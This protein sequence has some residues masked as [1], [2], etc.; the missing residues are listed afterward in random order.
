[1]DRELEII[2]EMP[3]LES[4]PEERVKYIMALSTDDEKI[5]AIRFSNLKEEYLV[6]I[7]N[8]L[9]SYDKRIECLKY[10]E[11]A[12]IQ[13]RIIK[14]MS[15][16]S[17]EQKLRIV[18]MIDSEILKREI[19]TS[20]NSDDIKMECIP[21]VKTQRGKKLIILTLSD[22]NKIKQLG[23]LEFVLERKKVINS[24]K[25]EEVKR[26]AVHLIDD[27]RTITMLLI[28][29]QDDSEKEKNLLLLKNERNIA[30]VIS[31]FT[32]DDDKIRLLAQ[33]EDE[34]NK[35]LICMSMQEREKIKSM[36]QIAPHADEIRI[37]KNITYGI[38]IESEGDFYQFVM[39]LEYLLPRSEQLAGKIDFWK[40]EQ[41]ASLIRGV[42]VVSPVLTDNAK[43][44][45]D[46]YIICSLLQKAGLKA[47][48]RCGGHIHIGADHLKSKE[49]YANLL[50]ICG[51]T[52]EI[53]FKISNEKGYVPRGDVLET[54][55]SISPKINRAVKEGFLDISDDT[56]L[57]EFIEQIKDAQEERR[58]SINFKKETQRTIEFRTPN[59]TIN[60]QTWVDNIR[61][62][63][64]IVE[65]S[66]RL[67]EIEN[68]KSL[69]VSEED[70]RLLYL[71]DRLTKDIPEEEKAEMLCRLLFKQDEREIYMERYRVNSELI[72][73]LPREEDVLKRLKFDSVV[74]DERKHVLGEFAEIAAG[75]ERDNPKSRLEAMRETLNGII[76]EQKRK[77]EGRERW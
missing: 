6:E 75:E 72:S 18:K 38:E 23:K 73:E 58:Y 36:L 1:M 34:R 64:R 29:M 27:E 46:I 7:V 62:F 66:E 24:I 21:L 12:S 16:L 43:S 35:A 52:E 69:S 48:E 70:I 47:S 63:G 55:K 50:E 57:N 71:R 14:A 2:K 41:D 26:K 77:M 74:I 53:L 39:E 49:A 68:S 30:R 42:E 61:L 65:I 76:A 17:D 44:I 54:A 13:K 22:E 59:G 37:D 20:I 19:A 5:F 51:N 25:D 4:K 45:E 67:A 56:D 32:F 15:G 3:G 9:S 31:S 33:I 10:F 60:P 11:D 40:A 28:S 8:S